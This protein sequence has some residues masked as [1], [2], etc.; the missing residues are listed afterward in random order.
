M[1]N[2]HPLVSEYA[3]LLH[4]IHGD[5]LHLNFHPDHWQ[6]LT[7]KSGLNQETI[8]NAQLFSVCLRD[9]PK[10]LDFNPEKVM[11]ALAFPYP[12]T[13]LVRL[14]ISPSYKD[15]DGKT[16]KYLQAKN[17]GSR[18]YI[19]FGIETILKNSEIPLNIIEGDKKCLRAIQ[20]GL[21]SIG[22]AGIW[23]W[24][25]NKKPIQDLDLIEWKNRKVTI[26]PD[27]DVVSNSDVKN[28]TRGLGQEL[29]RRGAIVS[30]ALIPQKVGQHG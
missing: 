9:I 20:E 4:S 21:P 12:G 26:F 19:P 27:G 6:D 25:S 15:K 28:G 23:G 3:P 24:S 7:E 1:K 17:S 13:P 2:I 11:S 18:L 16:V 10:I 22:I 8:K 30:V 29:K 14:K 5:D